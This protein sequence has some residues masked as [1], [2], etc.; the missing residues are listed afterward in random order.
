M[1]PDQ[2]LA[3]EDLALLIW[4]RQGCPEGKAVEH[5]LEAEYIILSRSLINEDSKE[6]RDNYVRSRGLGSL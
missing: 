1:D 6:Q 3:I 5:W 4:K 2:K